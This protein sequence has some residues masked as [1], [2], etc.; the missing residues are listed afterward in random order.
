VQVLPLCHRLR[1]AEEAATVDRFSHGRLIFG[2]GTPRLAARRFG[3]A[4]AAIAARTSSP[5]P[6]GAGPPCGAAPGL[7]G[8][9]CA[10][11]LLNRPIGLRSRMSGSI[12][13]MH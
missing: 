9:R 5:L 10:H 1:F 12:S 6:A 11:H 3:F 2:I 4:A 8:T 13:A 7:N